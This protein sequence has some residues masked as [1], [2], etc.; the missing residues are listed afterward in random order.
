[1]ILGTAGH[2]DHGKTTLVRALT[3]VDTDRLPEE[4]RRGI[5]IEL[6]FAPLEIEG[7]GTIGIVDVPGHEGFVRTMLAGAT[8]I[9]L[10]LLVIAAD[11]G[12]MPQTREHVAILDL[13]GVRA[14]VVALTKC[15]LVDA[16]WLTLVEE[17]VQALL[18]GTPL[19][20]AAIVATSATTGAGLEELQTAIA[21]AA[22][23][24]PR[25][26]SADLF[27]MPVDRAFT[28]RGTGTVVT[29]TI[30]TGRLARDAV[31]RILPGDRQARVRGL[32]SHGLQV[33][34]AEAGNRTAVALAGVDLGEVGRGTVLVTD[35]SWAATTVLRAEVALLPGASQSL[36]ARSAVR[37]HLGTAEVGARVVVAG[38]SLAPGERKASRIV[39]DEPV[40]LRAG[41]RFVLRTASPL[42]TVGGGLVLD[43]FAPRRGRAWPDAELTADRRLSLALAEA[44]PAGLHPGALPIR[45]GLSPE[46][47]TELIRGDEAHSLLVGSRL[48]AREFVAR[49]ADQLIAFVSESHRARPLDPGVSLQ[50]ARSQLSAP[51]ELVDRV[52]SDQ[53]AAGTVEVAGGLIRLAGWAPQPSGS[54]QEAIEHIYRTLLAAAH[55]PPSVGELIE[56][57]GPDAEGYLHFLERQ[58][59]VTQVET[60][61]YYEARHLESLLNVLAAGMHRG[62]EYAPAEL[63]ELLGV[64]RK[65]LIPLLEYCDRLGLT[66]RG[67]TGRFWRGK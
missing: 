35:P 47:T 27:R 34:S 66:S 45:L 58:G 54:Q 40:A 7:L 42:S 15:D 13:L 52:I 36:R 9:D 48:V 26:D 67:N 3:G 65:Y 10:A 14:G 43:P 57:C 46:A 56:S 31:V 62:Q 53:I 50:L 44:G 8:G 17:D 12:V 1:M 39:L 64:S 30:W 21:T 51:T 33:D 25:R 59:R 20:G 55:E 16:E 61:R 18:A 37:F 5:T 60:G 38:G 49:V 2:I 23:S 28:I 4:K 6:G 19:A 41:D 63:R 32:Q 22:R 11:E 29:G 24:L